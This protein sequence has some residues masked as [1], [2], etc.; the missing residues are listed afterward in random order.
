MASVIDTENE[1]PNDNSY[2]NWA[3]FHLTTTI[4]ITSSKGIT[5]DIKVWPMYTIIYQWF[6]NIII[7]MMHQKRMGKK[8][9]ECHWQK[10]SFLE[11]MKKL[12][13]N[14]SDTV[15]QIRPIKGIIPEIYWNIFINRNV[16]KCVK[17]EEIW[18]QC[19]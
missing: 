15:I 14:C 16:N 10:Q 5:N 19:S 6:N 7:Y 8:M 9:F 4:D 12:D 17:G 13:S 2:C 18:R 11:E 3:F 1:Y